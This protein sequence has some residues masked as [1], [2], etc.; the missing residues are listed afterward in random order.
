VRE[1]A[2]SKE[3]QANFLPAAEY[4]RAKTVDYG[5]MAEVQKAFSDRYTKEVQ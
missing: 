3:A 4:A 2:I 5:K 1:T